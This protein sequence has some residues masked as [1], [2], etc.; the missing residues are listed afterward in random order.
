[1]NYNCFLYITFH[2][3]HLQRICLVLAEDTMQSIWLVKAKYKVRNNNTMKSEA[4]KKL[5]IL[6][7][8]G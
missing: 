8:S 5:S 4:P 2:T 6:K 3:Y 7:V 1:M